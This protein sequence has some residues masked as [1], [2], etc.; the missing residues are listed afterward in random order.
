MQTK[1][2]TVLSNIFD[3]VVA[4]E[5]FVYEER[6][7]KHPLKIRKNCSSITINRMT[8]REIPGLPSAASQLHYEDQVVS[9]MSV[10]TTGQG[11]AGEEE[12]NLVMKDMELCQDL[13]KECEVRLQIVGM[14]EWI[15]NR[16]CIRSMVKYGIIPGK[17]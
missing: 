17:L 1:K 13:L 15:V 5:V 10:L 12:D 9:D 2:T 6:V 7:E 14:L 8:V 11:R 16:I 4:Q 3:E